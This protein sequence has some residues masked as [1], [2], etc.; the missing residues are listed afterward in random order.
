M[1][2]YEVLRLIQLQKSDRAIAGALSINRKTV[3]KYRAWA[4]SQGLLASRELP[5]REELHRR[6]AETWPGTLEAGAWIASDGRTRM[7]ASQAPAIPLIGG[8]M[9]P[10]VICRF[11]RV[12]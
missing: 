12:F 3:G 7:K 8:S 9:A 11:W 1:D 10:L 2:V 6:L 4:A 5:S